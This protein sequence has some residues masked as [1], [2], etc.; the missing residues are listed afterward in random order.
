MERRIVKGQSFIET[1]VLTLLQYELN[2]LGNRDVHLYVTNQFENLVCSLSEVYPYV[3]EAYRSILRSLLEREFPELPRP[4]F[5]GCILYD[6]LLEWMRVHADKVLGGRAEFMPE[7]DVERE[8]SWLAMRF[9]RSAVLATLHEI[10]ALSM[11]G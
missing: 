2:N 3:G 7:R 8:L 1:V 10:N 6:Q 5:R 11:G 9:I 4:E